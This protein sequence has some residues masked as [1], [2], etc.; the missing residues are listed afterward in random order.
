MYKTDQEKFWAGEFGN[1]YIERNFDENMVASSLQFWS[2]IISKTANIKSV[3]EYGPNVG[4]NLRAIQKLIPSAKLTGVEINKT[5]VEVLREVKGINVFNESIIN[6]KGEEKYDLVFTSGVLIHIDP[7]SLEK[8]YESMYNAS[9][10]YILVAEYYNP[11]PVS[12]SY[13]GEDDKLFKRDFA[14]DLLERFDNLIL[15]DY[16][17]QYRRDPNFPLDDITWFLLEKK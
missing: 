13:R 7:Q 5:A 8:V 2:K 4:I 14:G 17:F 9:S 16:G 3:I 6:F 12:I 1:Q 11:T 10:K 15:V